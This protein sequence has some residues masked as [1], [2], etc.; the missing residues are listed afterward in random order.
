MLGPAELAEL[1]VKFRT[2]PAGRRLVTEAREKS[3]VRK[4]RSSGGNVVTHYYS[5]KMGRVVSTESHT[6]EQAGAYLYEFDKHVLEY[7]PQPTWLDLLL[8]NPE[9]GRV[10]GRGHYPDF[11]VIT[12][13]CIYLD[14]WKQASYDLLDILSMSGQIARRTALV[15]FPRYLKGHVSEEES[16]K[17]A[18]RRLV[19]SM[20]IDGVGSLMEL[21]DQLH[22]CTNGCIGVLK[23]LLEKALKRALDNGGVW[24]KRHL[25]KSLPNAPQ[26]DAMIREATVGEELLAKTDFDSRAWDML[27]ELQNSLRDDGV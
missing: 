21:S 17:L 7:W 18:M 2:P 3:P 4:V 25:S 23:R 26:L 16:Y 5:P 1:F 20:P 6:A 24:K 8:T 11:M 10:N 15:H 14:E 27:A 19:E 12:D 22:S 9:T 13:E